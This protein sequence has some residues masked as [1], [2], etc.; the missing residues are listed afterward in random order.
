LKK[1]AE[2]FNFANENSTNHSAIDVVRPFET[3]KGRV[4][5]LSDFNFIDHEFPPT[6]YSLGYTLKDTQSEWKRHNET[7]KNSVF[8]KY[9]D[10]NDISPGKLSSPQ[11]LSTLSA[12]AEM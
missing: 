10:P 1:I 8:G 11:F 9:I 4:K 3:E 7:V 12:L 5:K 2:D 6:S